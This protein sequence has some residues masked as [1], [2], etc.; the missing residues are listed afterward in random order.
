[1]PPRVLI[2]VTGHPATGKTTLSRHLA[3]ALGL[4]L[5]SKDLL[6]ETIFDSL[7]W[8]DRAWSRRVGVTAIALLYT[9]TD[10][11]LQ[12]CPA[13][14]VESNFRA[15]LDTARMRELQARRPFVP[16]QIRCV[17][18]GEVQVARLRARIAAGERHP[19]HCDEVGPA[20]L[21]LVRHRGHIEP[22][23]LDGPLLTVDTTCPETINDAA[24]VSWTRAA[25]APRGAPHPLHA[26]VTPGERLP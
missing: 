15:D 17:A 24:V 20:D 4:P 23:G 10:G 12:G 1:M 14:I 22:L 26:P 16:V 2:I 6:K 8:S 21:E 7:G 11:L 19:G 5:L 18:S 9:L 3:A 25:L 13:L